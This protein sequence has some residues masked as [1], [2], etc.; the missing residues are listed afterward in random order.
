MDVIN[1]FRA[2]FPVI[3]GAPWSFAISLTVVGLIIW[4]VVR[5]SKAKEIGDLESRG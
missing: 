1:T 4:A 5:W 3:A 2:E